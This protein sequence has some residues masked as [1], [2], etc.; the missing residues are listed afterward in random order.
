MHKKITLMNIIIDK[1]Y[2]IV[3]IGKKDIKYRVA[4]ISD[5]IKKEIR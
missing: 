1:I 3:I 4:E 5:E 2:S